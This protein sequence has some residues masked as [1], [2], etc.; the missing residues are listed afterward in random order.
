MCVC[1][2]MQAILLCEY[3]V[4]LGPSAL[5]GGRVIELGAGTGLVGFVASYLGKGDTQG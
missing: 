3:L 5:S 2:L 1:V 4:H